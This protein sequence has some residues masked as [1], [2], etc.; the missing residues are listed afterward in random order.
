MI[1]GISGGVA[2]YALLMAKAI[3]AT[4]SVTSR[5]EEK[6]KRAPQLG[7]D[8]AFDSY[9]NWDEQLQGKR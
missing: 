5:S 2:T 7:A 4:V 8:Y 3:G 6:R 9:N 1:P